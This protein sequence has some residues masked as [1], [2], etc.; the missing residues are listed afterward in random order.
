MKVV[1]YTNCQYKGLQHF[2]EMFNK[3]TFDIIENYD[4]IK[5]KKPIPIDI[6]NQAD[7]FIYQPIDK[8][9]GIYSTLNEV[10][11]NICSYLPD[12]CKKISFPYIYNSAFWILIPPAEI[13]NCIGNYVNDRYNNS[14]SIELLKQKGK[15]LN[16]V[17]QMYNEHLIDFNYKNRFDN[18][19]KIL[20]EK[21]KYC[22]IKVSDFIINNKT[23]KL[24]LTQNHPTTCVYL[25]CINQLLVLLNEEYKFDEF[26][27]PENICSFPCEWFH[28][29][30]DVQYWN[31]EY[32]VTNINNDW[33]IQHITHIYNNYNCVETSCDNDFFHDCFKKYNFEYMNNMDTEILTNIIRFHI[34][35]FQKQKNDIIFDVGT[36]CG[37][38]IKVLTNLQIDENIHCF[39]P[40]PVLSK[41]TKD[42]YKNVVMNQ[43]CLSNKNGTVDVNFPQTSIAISSMIDRPLFKDKNWTSFDKINKVKC[44][45]LTLDHYC[46]TNNINNIYFIKIDVEGA[47]KMVLDGAVQMLK[48]NS[49]IGG[50]IEIIPEQLNDGG[51]SPEEIESMLTKY[52]YNIIKTL[53]TNDWYFHIKQKRVYPLSFSIPLKSI[54]NIDIT[55]KTRKFSPL[56]P[57]DNKTYIY[58]D[59]LSYNENYRESFF[60]FTYKK[61][62]YDCLRHYEILANNC[63]PYFINIENIPNLTMHNFPKDLCSEIINKQKCNNLTNNEL[64]EY[65]EK[66]H[67]YTLN[68]LT[69][70]KSAEY[71]LSIVKKVN[72]ITKNEIK[73]LLLTSDFQNYSIMMLSYGLRMLLNNDF[74]DYP[75]LSSLYNGSVF[76]IQLNDEYIDRSNIESKIQSHYY[77][78]VIIGS[79]GPDEPKNNM[80][81]YNYVK[82]FYSKNEIVFILGGDRP[83][84]INTSNVFHDFLN[85]ISKYGICFV[86]EL[87]DNTSYSHDKSWNEYYNECIIKYNNYIEQTKLIL[88]NTI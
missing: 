47:E 74:V 40:H 27:Y 80:S 46:I 12:H 37:S 71:F 15:L 44:N 34:Q 32:N 75:K 43:I 66:L 51:T 63:I 67:Y 87:D 11:N 39:E 68:N 78:I 8:T 17:I 9:H 73:V 50:I 41:K 49:I 54:Q 62:G 57:G 56:I 30:Y 28:T 70:E 13:D 53:S 26:A 7:I 79:V 60:A 33:Y 42:I 1:F 55:K 36:N 38:F 3:Y 69:C 23:K 81:Y 77:D 14:E 16:E 65:I 6:L 76:N 58:K 82:K 18:D 29:S 48:Q 10:E 52:G 88:N 86:R 20:Q 24:F 35:L 45:S 61:G 4:I 22:D 72:C 5:N 83:Y 21:E 19:I 59:E 31:F 2:L 64:H 85:S 84:N 25:H